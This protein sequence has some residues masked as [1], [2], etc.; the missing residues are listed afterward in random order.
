MKKVELGL[1][2]GLLAGIIDLFPLGIQAFVMN[3]D[4][5]AF[6]LFVF[7]IWVVLLWAISGYLIGTSNIKMNGTLKGVLVSFLI[8]IPCGFFIIIV[9]NEPLILLPIGIMALILGGILGFLIDKF[10]E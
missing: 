2:S 9:W 4:L 6:I 1:L 8:S 7:S 3:A 10:G 5:S